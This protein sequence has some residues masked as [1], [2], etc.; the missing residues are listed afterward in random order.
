MFP[1]IAQRISSSLGLG[2]S[3]EQRHGDEHHPGRAEA[4]LEPVFLVEA[5]LDRVS[6]PPCM[7]PST[8]VSSRPSAWTANIVQD[9][10]GTPSTRTVQ[11]PQLVVSQ[12]MWV[13]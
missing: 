4:A 7:Q 10:T 1:E 2:F 9:F 13:P 12:P 8:V 5:L 6:S 3:F 11:A